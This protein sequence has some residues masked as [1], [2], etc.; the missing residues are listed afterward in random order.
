MA[1]VFGRIA[2]GAAP[3]RQL[4]EADYGIC[5]F[6]CPYGIFSVGRLE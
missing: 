1:Y 3:G 6:A 5:A 2:G 4:G